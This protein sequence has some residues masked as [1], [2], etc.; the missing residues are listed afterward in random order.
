MSMLPGYVNSLG[1]FWRLLYN[2][3]V[4]RLLV[5]LSELEITPWQRKMPENWSPQMVFLDLIPML[6]GLKTMYIDQ[7]S[8]RN[9]VNV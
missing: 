2:A 1:A 5:L 9:L 7:V 8:V 6:W 3:I 4:L